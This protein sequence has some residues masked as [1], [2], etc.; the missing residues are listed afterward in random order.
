MATE[1][2]EVKACLMQFMKESFYSPRRRDDSFI[3]RNHVLYV[4]VD[5]PEVSQLVRGGNGLGDVSEG[6]LYRLHEVVP[7]GEMRGYGAG[8]G[9]A[10]A[11]G[12]DAQCAR[13][14]PAMG[15]A[16]FLHQDI[17]AGVAA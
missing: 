12:G 11:V 13:V 4:V 17:G 8:Q 14:R 1:R 5:S 10:C 2:A 3:N 6:E 15:G 9:A 7:V 16:V